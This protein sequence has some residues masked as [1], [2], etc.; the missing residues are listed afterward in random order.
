MENLTA[1]FNV[2]VGDMAIMMPVD[3]KSGV[4]VKGRLTNLVWQPE[5]I[6]WL[7]VM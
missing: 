5:G 6:P 4:F 2:T 1:P 3:L 7:V